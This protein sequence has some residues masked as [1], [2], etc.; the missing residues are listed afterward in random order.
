MHGQ[1]T[2]GSDGPKT[3]QEKACETKGRSADHHVAD[4]SFPPH[5]STPRTPF[6]QFA[7]QN[8]ED[9]TMCFHLSSGIQ[10]IR[11]VPGCACTRSI[12]TLQVGLSHTR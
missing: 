12:S 5:Q 6:L 11:V 7:S 3:V 1:E 10:H 2:F 9:P 8:I 4:K